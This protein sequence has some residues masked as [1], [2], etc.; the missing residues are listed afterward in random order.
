MPMIP[1]RMSAVQLVGHGGIDQLVYRSDVPVPRPGPGEVLVKVTATA[2][3]NTDRKVREG[4]YPT[5]DDNDIASF[6][7]GG[8][9]TLAFPRIQGADVVGRIVATGS[10]VSSARI[11]V[12]GLL[13]FNIYND[14]RADIN[15][16]PDYYGH[17][18]DG[19]FAEYIV[20]P[21]D[22]FHEVP[23]AVMS[24]AELS[25]LGMC[26]YQTACTCSRWRRW[27]KAT[28]C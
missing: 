23:V 26:S 14:D 15:L 22:Q 6:E 3:N 18:R 5:R 21:D 19:G 11:G 10:D 2:K 28:T 4:L 12:R 8:S 1:E 13:D 24:D 7:I 17:G 9:A 16:V 20:V 27:V 25:V